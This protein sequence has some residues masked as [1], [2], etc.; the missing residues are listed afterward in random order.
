MTAMP[1]DCPDEK[2]PWV[3]VA[4]IKMPSDG[5]R[6]PELADILHL[7]S[8]RM[9]PAEQLNK[10]I[11]AFRE[12]CENAMEWGNQLNPGLMLEVQFEVSHEEMLIRVRDQGEGFDPRSV[13]NPDVIPF[14]KIFTERRVQG[15]RVGG[16]GL[17]AVQKIFDE[18]LFNEKG[19]EVLVR[20]NLKK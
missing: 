14:Q 13:P 9:V 19:N 7:I 16:L 15:K 6:I 4:V 10:L 11:F 20:K 3:T 12:L 8:K 5:E 18:M 17:Y 2:R 1:D